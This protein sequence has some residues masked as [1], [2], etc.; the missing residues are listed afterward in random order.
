LIRFFECGA[1]AVVFRTLFLGN[2]TQLRA[3]KAAAAIVCPFLID[4]ICP[5]SDM[6]IKPTFQ[7]SQQ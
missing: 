4:Q 5:L 2:C 7:E 3:I 1:S 6:L